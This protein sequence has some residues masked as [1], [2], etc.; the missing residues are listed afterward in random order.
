MICVK[1]VQLALEKHQVSPI[2]VLSVETDLRSVLSKNV[3]IVPFI[4]LKHLTTINLFRI[5]S[6][7]INE[8]HIV[9][10]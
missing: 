8:N 10:K 5:G 3:L 1:I 6:T 2:L 7:L 4:R 9:Q